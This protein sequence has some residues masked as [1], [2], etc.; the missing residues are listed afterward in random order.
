MSEDP[1]ILIDD[2]MLPEKGSP[3][4]ANSTRNDYA[5]G[6]RRYREVGEPVVCALGQGGAGG[7]E[8]LEV[9]KIWRYTEECDDCIIVAKPKG[10]VDERCV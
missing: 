9:V 10:G 2:T 1:V 8:D 3:W 6:A 7:C 5:R 4:R